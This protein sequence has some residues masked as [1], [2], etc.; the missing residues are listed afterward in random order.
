ME[1]RSALIKMK[2]GK[3]FSPGKIPTEA[4]KCLGELAVEF[5]TNEKIESWAETIL[6]EWRSS[7]LIPIFKNKLDVQSCKGGSATS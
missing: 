6:E 5:L 3:A 7:I 2:G 1:V 4:R